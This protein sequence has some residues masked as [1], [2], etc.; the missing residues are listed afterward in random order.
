MPVSLSVNYNE[1]EILE[2]VEFQNIYNDES[3]IE[4]DKEHIFNNDYESEDDDSEDEF[5]YLDQTVSKDPSGNNTE[6]E[7]HPNNP[8]ISFKKYNFREVEKMVDD[9]YFEDSHRYSSSL[10]ILATYLRGQKLIY[11]ESTSFSTNRLNWLM[12]PSIFL[13]TAATVLSTILRDYSWGSYIIAGMNGGIAFLLALVSYLKL[14]AASE[15]HNTSAY[16]YDKL[17]TSIEFMSG[18]TLLFLKKMP[19]DETIND[20]DVSELNERNVETRLLEQLSHTEKKISDIKDTNQF[21]IPKEIRRLYPIIYNT[22]IFLLIKKIQDIKK[23]KINNLKEIKNRKNYL[24]AVLISKHKKG[25]ATSVKKLQKRILHLY[26]L[27]NNYVKEILILKSSFSVIDEMFTKE[28]EN[29]ELLTRYWLRNWLLCGL[30]MSNMVTD[31]KKMNSFI[32]DIMDPYGAGVGRETHAYNEFLKIKECIDDLNKESFGKT[33]KLLKRVIELGLT[34]DNKLET[35]N[36]EFIPSG[37][38]FTRKQSFTSAG[39]IKLFGNH[40]NTPANKLKD[41][42]NANYINKEPTNNKSGSD[43]SESQMDVNVDDGENFV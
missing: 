8:N 36:T 17:Q 10:D 26:E 39:L 33:H 43:S 2:E 31:P 18:K 5:P 16:Q 38:F 12:M 29:A 28:M 24:S 19:N 41:L 30:G 11:M 3:F 27:K 13:S 7:S 15:A 9:N 6:E 20:H 21:L 22:N 32:I 34:I 4:R 1:D 37:N 40:S 14:D 35:H 23:R 42:Y 25:K